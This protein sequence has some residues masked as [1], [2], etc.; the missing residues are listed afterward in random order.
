MRDRNGAAP[1]SLRDRDAP[2][3]HGADDQQQPSEPHAG[4]QPQTVTR[5]DGTAPPGRLASD[6][7]RAAWQAA[8]SR[9]RRQADDRPHVTR[10]GTRDGTRSTGRDAHSGSGVVSLK[11]RRQAALRQRIGGHIASNPGCTGND[12]QAAIGGNRDHLLTALRQLM[13]DGQVTRYHDPADKR[14]RRYSPAVA[15]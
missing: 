11:A 2:E 10:D 12:L 5:A 13:D 1:Q 9:K 6:T 3:D 15:S 7:E 8:E 14:I 4:A